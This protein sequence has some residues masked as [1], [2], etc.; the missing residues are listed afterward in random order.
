MEDFDCILVIDVLTS[1]RATVDCYQKVVQFRPVE[2]DSWFF[3]GEGVPL[4]Q[5]TKKDVPF[6]W[7]SECEQSFDELRGRLNV[8]PVLAL[9]SGTRGYVVYT[10]ASLKGL[11]C[12][13][14]QNGHVIAYSSR[15]LKTHKGNYP[16]HDLGLAAIMLALK[17]WHHYLYG[18]RLSKSAHFL[19]YN[20]EF[21]FDRIARLYIQE[22]MRIHGVPLSII[23]DRDPRLTSWFWGSFQ[24]VLG[25]TMSLSTTYHPEI[26]GQSERI[27]QTLEDML[28][29]LVMDFGLSWQDHLP[30]IEFPY[31]TAIIV[32]FIKKRIK[33][34]QDRHA[35]Y[36]N[37]KRRQLHF[38]I[39][40]Y[41]FLRVSPF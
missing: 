7:S 23:S 13:L 33:A 31:K 3:Y 32:E 37:T 8:A 29:T 38:E 10:D 9:P 4:T 22:I 6:V 36:A 41:V 1:Y 11:G 2:G 15:Q 20:H 18:E 24:R 40:E 19:T 21:T 12:V 30:V 25:T 16:V 5:L 39:G 28:R 27:I 26:D 17:I 34:T 14:K 35:G